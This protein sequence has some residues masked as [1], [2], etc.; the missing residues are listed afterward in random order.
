MI[1]N[2]IFILSHQD[3]EFGLFNIIEKQV[4]E[5]KNVLIFFLTSGYS[6]LINKFNLSNRDKESLK[7]LLNLGIKKKNIFFLGR[8]LNIKIYNL[9]KYLDIIYD[10]IKIILKQNKNKSLIFTHAWEGGNEDHD[11]CYVIVKKIFFNNSNI[12]KCYKFSQYHAYK[13]YFFPFKIQDHISNNKDFLHIKID[14]KKKIKY[15]KYLF[16]YL[17]QLYIW[18]PV[19]PFVIY[20]ILSNQYGKLLKVDKNLELKRPHEGKLLYEKLRNNKYQQVFKYFQ[21]FLNKKNFKSQ[22]IS[23]SIN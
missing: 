5:K 15:I 11:S 23:K 6:M 21:K 10:Q 16:C 14:F 19:Y 9:H 2:S 20:K 3:D 1:R 22:K 17:S 13:S 7:V 18:I 4:E 12:I 8:K